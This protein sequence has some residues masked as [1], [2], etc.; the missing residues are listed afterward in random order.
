MRQQHVVEFH[1]R[2][3]GAMDHSDIGI[4][5]TS[6]AGSKKGGFTVYTCFIGITLHV[7]K[8]KLYYFQ[9]RSKHEGG[10]LVN[11]SFDLQILVVGEREVS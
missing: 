4:Q 6:S 9:V 3:L 1:H 5:M 10:V 7:L 8:E 11:I 2:Y